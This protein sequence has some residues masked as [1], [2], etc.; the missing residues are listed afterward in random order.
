MQLSRSVEPRSGQEQTFY[1]WVDSGGRVHI[2]SSLDSIPAAERGKASI[3][4][5]DA[6]TATHGEYEAPSVLSWRP[7][8][9]SFGAGFGAAVVLLVVYQLLPSS[10]RGVWRMAV[11]LA[12]AA[13][14]AGA[15]LG[16]VRGSTT[17][18]GG[19]ALSSPG[20]L[21]DDAKSAVQ[22]MNQRQAEQEQQLREIQS[23]GAKPR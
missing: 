10:L 5:L 22:R 20:A 8:W 4:Q 3:V 18:P 2:V 17:A 12:L 19:A 9:L 6:A 16:L 23:E 1:R 7:D 14:M 11:V 21:I 13:G 15:Y